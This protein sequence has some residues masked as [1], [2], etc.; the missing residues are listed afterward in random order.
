M[1]TLLEQHIRLQ[2]EIIH[3]EPSVALDRLASGTLDVF[4]GHNISVGEPLIAARLADLRIG[5]YA[6]VGHPLHGR[7]DVSAEEIAEHPFAAQSRPGLMRSIWPAKVKRRVNL[8]TDSHAVALEAC[9]DG[10]H[11]MAMERLIARPF[12]SKN[13]LTEINTSLISPAVLTLCRHGEKGKSAI[14][15]AVSKAITTTVKRTLRAHPH[16]A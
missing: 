3:L 1:K 7:K 11:L 4:L 15:S 8:E 13:A 5:I 2:A 9:L 12:V 6:G 14:I 10:S 16:A